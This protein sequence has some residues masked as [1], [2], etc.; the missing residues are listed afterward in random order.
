MQ[1]KGSFGYKLYRKPMGHLETPALITRNQVIPPKPENCL[2]NPVEY[3]MN[4]ISSY[5]K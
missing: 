5:G 1:N 3:N 4:V 2:A